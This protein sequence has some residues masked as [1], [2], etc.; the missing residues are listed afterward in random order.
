MENYRPYV[1]DCGT[2][3]MQ[4]I[5]Y[6]FMSQLY[7][8]ISNIKPIGEYTTKSAAPALYREVMEGK[9][10]FKANQLAGLVGK[11]RHAVNAVMR[12]TLIPQEYV[13]KTSSWRGQVEVYEYE[14]I[15]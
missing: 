1:N 3:F 8:F 6:S 4:G 15:G 9:G 5:E 2:T 10:K 14:W 13:R 11:T 12:E 7:D